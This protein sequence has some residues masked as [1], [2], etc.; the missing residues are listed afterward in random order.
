MYKMDREALVQELLCF[1]TEMK[2]RLKSSAVKE[3]L[4]IVNYGTLTCFPFQLMHYSVNLA[5]HCK[6]SAV[7][8]YT[9]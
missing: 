3:E 6:H 8:A 9:V 2:K 1:E 4:H 5:Y 7:E